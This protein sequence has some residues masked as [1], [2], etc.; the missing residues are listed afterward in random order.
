MA[1]HRIT[2]IHATAV[3]IAPTA[4]AF[5]E[6]WPE[7]ETANLLE[8]SL[9]TDLA[10]AGRMTPAINGRIAALALYGAEAGADGILFTCSAFGTAID[11]AKSEFTIPVLKPN[12]AL[13]DDAL[14]AGPHIVLLATFAPTIVSMGPEFDEAAA[15]RGVSFDLTCRHVPDA[16]AALGDGRADVHDD[17]IAGAAAEYGACD[18][19][20]LAQFSMARARAMIAEVP[21]RR[22]VTSPRSAV[23]RMKSLLGA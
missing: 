2:L 22:V 3:S 20:V 9:S 8:D 4:D 19:L 1:A 14:D 5:A 12:E 21:G 17:L 13:I 18:A 6:L 11:A 10:A 15:E 16:M 23:L 7:A